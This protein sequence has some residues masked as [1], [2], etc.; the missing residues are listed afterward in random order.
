MRLHSGLIAALAL[1][2]TPAFAATSYLVTQTT[3]NISES[4]ICQQ[5]SNTGAGTRYISTNTASEWQSFVNNPNGL[6][7][8][9]CPVCGAGGQSVGG[10][11]WYMGAAG[12]TCDTVCSSHGACN[13]TGTRDY[14][15]SGGTL[16]NCQAVS[17]AL[18]KGTASDTTAA[19]TVGCTYLL[20]SVFRITSPATACTG[21]N[22]SY[23]RFCA[24]N[25]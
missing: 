3:I 8:A 15:G 19:I 16:A 20:G 17:T 22:A 6:G 23:S 7:M 12:Q 4:N 21:S 14:A 10:Y 24:C 25:N 1:L 9:A 18:G 2:A 5:V 13:L 11:C